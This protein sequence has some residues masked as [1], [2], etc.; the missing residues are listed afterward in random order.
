MKQILIAVFFSCIIFA[1]VGENN[2]ENNKTENNIEDNKDLEQKDFID[3]TE[4]DEQRVKNDLTIDLNVARELYERAVNYSKKYPQSENLETVIVYAAKGAEDI[5]DYEEAVELYHMLA[6]KLPETNKTPVHLY[7]KAKVLEEKMG[8]IESA[9]AAYKELIDKYPK[10]PISKSVRTY[11]KKG[12]IDMT[13][14]EKIIYYKE[15]N[16]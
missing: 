14:E 4:L 13:P 11:L 16:K 10:N 15:Q 3:L 12:V 8:K 1:C 7:N 9:K 2:K 5:G 6:N